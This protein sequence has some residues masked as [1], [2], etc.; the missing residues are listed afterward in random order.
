M[1][2]LPKY[3]YF[4]LDE[5]CWILSKGQT[6][7][8]S[9]AQAS[10]LRAMVKRHLLRH[11]LLPKVAFDNADTQQTLLYETYEEIHASSIKELLSY[12]KSI[13]QA[14]IFRY[15]WSNWYRPAF[16]NVG[17]RWEIASLCGRPGS[18]ASI[19][20]SRTTMRLESHWRILK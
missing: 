3:L 14:K 16:G 13:D 5:T 2:A 6:K 9:P 7:Q 1:S 11:T 19:P 12:C 8:C 15:F 17:S 4:L 20:I 10:V 18:V